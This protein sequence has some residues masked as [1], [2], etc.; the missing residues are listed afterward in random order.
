MKY[1]EI[2]KRYDKNDAWDDLTSRMTE[3]K[4]LDFL[5]KLVTIKEVK[6]LSKEFQ[7]TTESEDIE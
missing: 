3:E 1:E 5:T 7:D 4:T 2:K 6:K